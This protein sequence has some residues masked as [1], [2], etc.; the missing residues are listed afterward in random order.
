MLNS[1]ID[2]DEENNNQLNKTSNTSSC[3][4]NDCNWCIFCD[5]T[6]LFICCSE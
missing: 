1:L 4:F 5:L 6:W 2:N 3:S